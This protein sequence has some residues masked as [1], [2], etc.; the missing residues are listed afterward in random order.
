MIVDTNGLSAWWLNEPSFIPHIAHA[1]RLC[2]PVPA[3]AEFRF[4]IL[5]S[6]FLEK[7]TGWLDD[8][9]TTTTILV[10]DETTTR[11]YAEIRLQLASAGTPIPM[12]DL[13]IAAIAR[14]HK[15]PVLSRDAHFD[16]VTGLTRIGW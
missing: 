8:A 7:M 5:K 6:R 10:A 15:L 11:H 2:V 14:Q 4:G 1:D 16:H 3:L 9:L 13:W 12:N